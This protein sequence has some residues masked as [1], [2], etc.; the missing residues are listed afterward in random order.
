[1]EELVEKYLISYQKFFQVDIV[2][3]LL[4]GRE[5]EI[6]YALMISLNDD[7][8]SNEKDLRESKKS[9]N[10][11]EENINIYKNKI[12]EIF[13]V[14]DEKEFEISKIDFKTKGFYLFLET[15]DEIWDEFLEAYNKLSIYKDANIHEV[16]L[17]EFNNSL[18]H[19]ISYYSQND[20]LNLKRAKEHLYRAT[21]DAYKEII[22]DENHIII[23]N[24][25]LMKSYLEIRLL[26]QKNIGNKN[27][28]DKLDIIYKYKDIANNILTLLNLDT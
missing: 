21:L 13:T 17:I 7:I 20:N 12:I 6:L 4:Y 11:L 23:S 8:L 5:Y 18:S 9:I 28:N 3:S 24:K 15:I 16:L 22:N 14:I 2:I 1:M 10:F 27:N 26:E 19:I 25:E